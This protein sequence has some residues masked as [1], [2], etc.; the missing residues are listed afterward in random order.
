MSAF[1]RMLRSPGATR[2]VV[3]AAT[4]QYPEASKTG[5]DRA[6]KDVPGYT[7]KAK[8]GLLDR[9]LDHVVHASG[10]APVFIFIQTLL[11]VW[12][13]LG[14]PFYKTT[15]WPVVISDSQAIF[16][17]IFDSFLMRQQLNGYNENLTVVAEIRSRSRSTKRMLN[18]VTNQLGGDA[19]QI[20]RDLASRP[21]I[22]VQLPRESL[23]TKC[24]TL[25][26]NA[27]GSIYFVTFYWVCIFVWLGL[28]PLN[29][30]SSKLISMIVPRD[31]VNHYLQISGSLISIRQHRLV[32]VDHSG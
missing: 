9:G 30:W 13:F 15:I 17:Y 11:L 31:Q 26:A 7:V 19:Q 1:L 16:S 2:D 21:L 10:S 12:A 27:L 5:S 4:T 18:I 6:V 25:S 20:V 28:G 24:I 32:A 23:F 8:P 3:A 14:I 22:E 29:G